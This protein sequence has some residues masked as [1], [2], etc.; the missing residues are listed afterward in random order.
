M[1]PRDELFFSQGMALGAALT[2]CELRPA[3]AEIDER[4]CA[5]ERNLRPP[6]PRYFFVPAG[7]RRGR[8]TFF[9]GRVA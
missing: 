8:R 5:L 6:S 4:I 1:T 9:V 7:W 2:L 3:L